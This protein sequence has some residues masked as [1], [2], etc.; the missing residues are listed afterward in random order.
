M[1]L[2]P[3]E[4]PSA[5]CPLTQEVAITPDPEGHRFCR[6]D[7]DVDLETLFLL[8][9]T[10]ARARHR[11][12]QI[13]LPDGSGCLLAEMNTIIGLG[14]ASDPNRASRVRISF[15]NLSTGECHDPV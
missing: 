7:V 9:E 2:P 5:L 11:Q 4:W 15:H 14:R 8:N 10:E 13:P 12:V 6:I 3:V 1:A